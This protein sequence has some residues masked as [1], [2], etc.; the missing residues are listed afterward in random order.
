M[1]HFLTTTGLASEPIEVTYEIDEDGQVQ[2]VSVSFKGVDIL[3]V[4]TDD[5]AADLDMECAADY[6]KKEKQEKADW[7][8]DR[9][10]AMAE[11]MELQGAWA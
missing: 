7:I 6:R 10:Q 3:G 2:D 8:Y 9:G 11:D 5:T 4:L 1:Y